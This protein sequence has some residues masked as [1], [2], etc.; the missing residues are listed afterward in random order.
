MPITHMLSHP[1]RSGETGRACFDR[2]TNTEFFD[3]DSQVLPCGVPT[4]L[5]GTSSAELADLP[6]A[7]VFRPVNVE[8]MAFP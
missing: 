7:G 3:M 8:H 2:T 5:G 1:I 4:A 6:V